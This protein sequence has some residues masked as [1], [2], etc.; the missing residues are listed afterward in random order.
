MNRALKIHARLR[1]KIAGA[2][3]ERVRDDTGPP[4]SNVVMFKPRDPQ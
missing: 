2:W 4:G 1:D 3:D